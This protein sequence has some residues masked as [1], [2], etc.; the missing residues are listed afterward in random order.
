M[1]IYIFFL[2]KH[3]WI[4]TGVEHFQQYC[5]IVWKLA[6]S[7]AWTIFTCAVFCS[8]LWRKGDHP[9]KTHLVGDILNHGARQEPERHIWFLYFTLLCPNIKI[10]NSIVRASRSEWS[11]SSNRRLLVASGCHLGF[12]SWVAL[13]GGKGSKAPHAPAVA[14]ACSSF[15]FG[16]EVTR[17]PCIHDCPLTL[18]PALLPFLT[19]LDPLMLL[20]AACVVRNCFCWSCSVQANWNHW[21]FWCFACCAGVWIIEILRSWKQIIYRIFSAIQWATRFVLS[22]IFVMTGTL[23]VAIIFYKLES[24]VTII[25]SNLLTLLVRTEKC[26]KLIEWR[27]K[28]TSGKS[29]CHFF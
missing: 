12:W 3:R 6:N 24:L 1:Y 22:L 4:V 26:V 21:A 20:G 7:W 29:G 14:P 18:A 5:L 11:N 13:R 19:S 27:S 2:L 16:K 10:L 9:P 28:Y 23:V 15:D 17:L 25:W 8:N